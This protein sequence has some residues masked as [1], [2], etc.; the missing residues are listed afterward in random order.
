MYFEVEVGTGGITG[1]ADSSYFITCFNNVAN[2]NRKLG[3]VCVESL[4]SITVIDDYAVTIAAIPICTDYNTVCSGICR[5]ALA[6]SAIGNDIDTVVSSAPSGTYVGGNNSI[7]GLLEGADRCNLFTV[8]RGADTDN[9]ICG[10]NGYVD[11]KGFSFG[12]DTIDRNKLIG[13]FTFAVIAFGNNLGYAVA[14]RIGKYLFGVIFES[15]SFGIC[16]YRA[17][18]KLCGNKL[19]GIIG[20][21]RRNVIIVFLTEERKELF[22]I[23]KRFGSIARCDIFDII[24]KANLRFFIDTE[25]G[26]ADREKLGKCF[27]SDF[28]IA[29]CGNKVTVD[30]YAEALNIAVFGNDRFGRCQGRMGFCIF[31]CRFITRKSENATNRDGK[32]QNRNDCYSV[33]FEQV[34][35]F[36]YVRQMLLPPMHKSLIIIV[37]KYER[38][39]KKF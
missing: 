11:R 38:D 12:N 3:E 30:I 4:N 19:A 25:R 10:S 32:R 1:R 15:Y 36:G 17:N 24:I 14:K 16:H 28:L 6:G 13:F 29:Y 26:N 39:I 2:L 8:G 9:F 33:F 23:G 37:D 20:D 18:R 35:R 22:F 34:L 5:I 21:I 7:V 31:L 27:G